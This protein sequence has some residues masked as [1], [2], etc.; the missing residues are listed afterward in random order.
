MTSTTITM[1]SATMAASPQAFGFAIMNKLMFTQRYINV[2]YSQKALLF[3]EENDSATI[4]LGIPI[5]SFLEDESGSEVASQYLSLK[6]RFLSNYWNSLSTIL[7]ILLIWLVV[8]I[9]QKAT[10]ANYLNL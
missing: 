6:P 1:G 4:G 9:I 7:V 8:K 2:G 5:F 10:K 3:F